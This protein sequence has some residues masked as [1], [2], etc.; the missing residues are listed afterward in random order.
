MIDMKYLHLAIRNGVIK[1]HSN[2]NSSSNDDDNYIIISYK[3]NDNYIIITG[4][5]VVI[6]FIIVIHCWGI[7]IEAGVVFVGS[8]QLVDAYILFLS[9]HI[10]HSQSIVTVL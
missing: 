6:T 2:D 8:F 10:H 7:G 9:F 3:S 4:I 1:G 5:V